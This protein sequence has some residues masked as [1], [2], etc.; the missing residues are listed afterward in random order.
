MSDLV[1][2]VLCL[3]GFLL[4]PLALVLASFTAPWLRREGPGVAKPLLLTGLSLIGIL[5]CDSLALSLHQGGNWDYLGAIPLL[6]WVSAA[7]TLL[8]H[9]LGRFVLGVRNQAQQRKGS[10]RQPRV[11]S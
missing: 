1:L 11:A 5:V 10:W 3:A 9:G 4:V 8:G 7:G 2:L 6:P